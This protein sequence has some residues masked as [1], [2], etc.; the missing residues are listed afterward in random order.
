MQK[1]IYSVQTICA[2]KLLTTNR[3]I[4]AVTRVQGLSLVVVYDPRVSDVSLNIMINL[5]ETTH[6]EPAGASPR[7]D[8]AKLE[9]LVGGVA[10]PVG[11]GA[12]GGAGFVFEGHDCEEGQN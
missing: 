4:C 6:S 7:R 3:I 9:A 2:Q 8:S 1:V 10:G 5:T 12:A 11:P